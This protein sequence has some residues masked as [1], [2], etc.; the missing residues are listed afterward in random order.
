MQ[1]QLG[2]LVV[3]ISLLYNVLNNSES[4]YRE[5]L[6]IKYLILNIGFGF[7]LGVDKAMLVFKLFLNS[8]IN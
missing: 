5:P 4:I 8:I 7:G 3:N 2:K 1:R 6:A